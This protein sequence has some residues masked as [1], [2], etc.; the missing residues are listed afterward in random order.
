MATKISITNYTKKKAYSHLAAGLACGLS[1]LGAGIAIGIGGDAG[2][3]AL[4]QEDRIFVGWDDSA[5]LG[6]FLVPCHDEIGGL[7]HVRTYVLPLIRQLKRVF[8]GVVRFC[9]AAHEVVALEHQSHVVSHNGKRAFNDVLVLV[10]H[11]HF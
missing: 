6:V 4:G 2:V 3:R 10:C 7:V 8:V 9:I 5:Q 1:A 11:L